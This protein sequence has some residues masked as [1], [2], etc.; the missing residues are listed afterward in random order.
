MKIISV[1]M[2]SKVVF[3]CGNPPLCSGIIE[4]PSGPKSHTVTV[5]LA[6][7]T[8]SQD[9]VINRETVYLPADISR[10]LLF[11]LILFLLDKNRT[12]TPTSTVT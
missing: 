9:G 7:F 3:H 5:I 1:Q 11:L 2:S 8:P 10:Y 12:L 6:V 4:V